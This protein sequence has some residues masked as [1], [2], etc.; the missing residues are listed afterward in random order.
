M[1]TK[2]MLAVMFALAIQS[3]WS[4]V[5]DNSILV[6]AA[7]QRTRLWNTVPGGGVTLP[8]AFPPGATLAQLSVRGPGYSQDYPDITTN[9]V[10]ISLPTATDAASEAVYDLTLAFDD[11]SEQHARLAVIDGYDLGST[12]STVCRLP[13]PSVRWGRSKSRSAVIPIPAGPRNLTVD[14][15][16]AGEI[17]ADDS[18]TWFQVTGIGEATCALVLTMEEGEFSETLSL[19]PGFPLFIR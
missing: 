14:G 1:K 11:G 12:G 9:A 10:K 5:S 7:P 16:P 8:V 13:K 3:G 19:A 4:T 2:C 17:N 18:A 15:I 6:F